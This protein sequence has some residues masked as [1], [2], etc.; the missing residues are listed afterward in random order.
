MYQV[1]VKY[2]CLYWNWIWS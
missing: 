1:T 2:W